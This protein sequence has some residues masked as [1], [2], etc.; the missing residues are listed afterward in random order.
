[1]AVKIQ[2]TFK[3][4]EK[5]RNGLDSDEVRAIVAADPLTPIIVV[6]IVMPRST[7]VDY[8]DGGSRID[9]FKFQGIEVMTGD[10]KDAAKKL[11]DEEYHT[12]TGQTAPPPTLFDD[13]TPSDDDADHRDAQA[14][15]DQAARDP[16]PDGESGT[17]PGDADHV[18]DDTAAP[19][20]GTTKRGRR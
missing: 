4:A 8:E 6:A 18:D 14:E 7:E 1:M 19:A 3:K 10:H 15:A 12:R 13:G 5:E 20:T 17:W 16:D 2:G 9:K 11:L